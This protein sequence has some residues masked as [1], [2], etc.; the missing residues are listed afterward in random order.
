MPTRISDIDQLLYR[1]ANMALLPFSRT[2]SLPMFCR[3]LPGPSITQP[4]KEVNEFKPEAG[5]IVDITPAST[6]PQFARPQGENITIPMRNWKGIPFMLSDKDFTDLLNMR[7]MVVP[8]VLRENAEELAAYINRDIFEDSVP[9]IQNWVKT[10]GTPFDSW[11]DFKSQFIGGSDLELLKNEAPMSRGFVAE[12]ITWSK[13]R[14]L[15]PIIF[16]DQRGSDE[17]ARTG[18]VG[19]YGG[20]TFVPQPGVR[21]HDNATWTVAAKVTADGVNSAGAT[22]ITVDTVEPGVGDKFVHSSTLHTI[23]AVRAGASANKYIATIY[24]ALS[25]NLPNDAALTEYPYS[26]NIHLATGSITFMSGIIRP[27]VGGQNRQAVRMEPRTGIY[28][29]MNYFEG[30]F[31]NSFVMS[32]YWGSLLDRPEGVVGLG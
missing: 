15:D 25:A 21:P 1:I 6:V 14:Q 10:D 11:A 18:D 30:Y 20:T 3:R 5:G 22:D 8:S 12:P 24:P 13:V 16:A 27:Q 32:A 4:K 9:Q 23:T 7:R 2:I 17:T 31:Q 19:T 28:L 29:M 26:P